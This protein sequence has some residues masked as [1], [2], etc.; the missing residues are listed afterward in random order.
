MNCNN[1][2]EIVPD[3][4]VNGHWTEGSRGDGYGH[5]G[6]CCDCFDLKMGMPLELL[7]A[8][9]EAKGKPPLKEPA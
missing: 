5:K 4:V 2:E 7:N 6:L 8:E 1:C 3:R 9:R